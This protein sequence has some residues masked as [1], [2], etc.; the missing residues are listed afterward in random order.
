M[1]ADIAYQL[2]HDD[3]LLDGR[4]QL[5]LATLVAGSSPCGGSPAERFAVTFADRMRATENLWK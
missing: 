4:E 3:L 2:I 5:N 1:P